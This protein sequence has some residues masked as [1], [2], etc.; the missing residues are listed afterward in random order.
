M[1]E[2]L[3][4][5]KP[6]GLSAA[7]LSK[8]TGASYARVTARLRELEQAGEVKSS[9]TRRT[10]LWRMVTEERVAQRAAELENAQDQDES[11]AS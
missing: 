2:R 10:S 6:E 8:L 3:L 4:S 7:A 11:T 5:E 1:I 9:G